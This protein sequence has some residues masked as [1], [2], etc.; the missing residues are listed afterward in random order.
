M[1]SI[2]ELEIENRLLTKE[3]TQLKREREDLKRENKR[4]NA[5]LLEMR[6]EFKA[7][8][9]NEKNRFVDLLR[10]KATMKEK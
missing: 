1:K 7:T 2:E 9:E 10:T 6:I 5:E 3:N 8:I 4:L